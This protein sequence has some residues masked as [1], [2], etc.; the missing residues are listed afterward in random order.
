MLFRSEH[1]HTP[2]G[3]AFP[4]GNLMELDHIH[5]R[6]LETHVSLGLPS[7]LGTIPWN[8]G[9]IRYRE[10]ERK[11]GRERERDGEVWNGGGQSAV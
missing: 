10:R 2:L 9:P 4:T 5:Q 7:A 8:P 6:L 3:F 1:T 11:D